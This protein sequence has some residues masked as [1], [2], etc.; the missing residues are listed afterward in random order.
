M[1]LTCLETTANFPS[2]PPPFPPARLLLLQLLGGEGK[3]KKKTTGEKKTNK[4]KNFS[5]FLFY[6]WFFSTHTSQ[7]IYFSPFFVFAFSPPPHSARLPMPRS[8]SP[9]ARPVASG[10][11]G[12]GMA[13]ASEKKRPVNEKDWNERITAVLASFKGARLVETRRDALGI[14]RFYVDINLDDRAAFSKKIKKISKHLSIIDETERTPKEGMEAHPKQNVTYVSVSPRASYDVQSNDAWWEE[15]REF[16]SSRDM[17]MLVL[18]IIMLLGGFFVAWRHLKDFSDPLSHF[19]RH[20]PA[21]MF[22]A[23]DEACELGLD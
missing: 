20:A 11:V 19:K 10:H 23:H 16:F 7:G 1:A 9:A 4:K 14:Y 3:G 18:G 21:F 12:P 17:R 6:F 2:F 8:M 5:Q 22:P 15:W 13:V